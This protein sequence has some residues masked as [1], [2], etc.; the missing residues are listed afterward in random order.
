MRKTPRSQPQAVVIGQVL[1]GFTVGVAQRLVQ[2]LKADVAINQTQQMV[3]RDLI[4]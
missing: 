4:F 3:F 1:Q 2:V